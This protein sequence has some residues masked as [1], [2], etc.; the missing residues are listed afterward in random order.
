[1]K[2]VPKKILM[3]AMDEKGHATIT[4]VPSENGNERLK[5]SM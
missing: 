5:Q 3:S 1:M 2:S 4:T